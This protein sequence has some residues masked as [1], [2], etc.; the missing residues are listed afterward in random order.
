VL[1]HAAAAEIRV[2]ASV[3]RGALAVTGADLRVARRAMSGDHGT[4]TFCIVDAGACVLSPAYWVWTVQAPI[5]SG[6][7]GGAFSVSL[8]VPFDVVVVVSTVAEPAAGGGW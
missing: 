4:V 5:G 6:D 7:P 2:G 1:S 8:K 3:D